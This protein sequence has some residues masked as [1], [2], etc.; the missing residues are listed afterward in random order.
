MISNYLPPGRNRGYELA[1]LNLS[2]GLRGRGHDV[3]ILT[4]PSATAAED[5]DFV[6]RNLA[7]R[8]FTT[9]DSVGEDAHASNEFAIRV[10]QLDNTV[11]VL[12]AIRRNRPDHILLFNMVGLGGLA[13]VNAVDATG[14]PWSMNLG[15]WF[16]NELVGGVDLA[17][18]DVFD[19]GVG[20][21]IYRRAR[22]AA[23]SR[24]L[25]N[26]M[27][28]DGVDLGDTVTII[29]RGVIVPEIART[30]GYREGGVVRFVSAGALAPQ[31][32][33][34]HIIEAAAIVAAENE[35]PFVID[36]YG[37]GRRE[38]YEARVAELG[39]AD[40]I[41]FHGHVS[42]QEIVAANASADAFLCPTWEREPGASV[43]IEAGVAGAVP[44]LTATCGPG[45][46]FVDGFSCLKIFPNQD[47]LARAMRRIGRGEVDLEQLG[48]NARRL[49]AYDLSFETSL[50]RLEKF[51]AQ[52]RDDAPARRIDDPQLDKEIVL[53]DARAREL[54]EQLR[55]GR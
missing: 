16:P 6:W 38:F 12:D 47:S 51:L 11:A 48:A 8:E 4:S 53:K 1:C 14:I 45:E 55:E 15:D 28:G 25:V 37:T 18:R 24:T 42:Q 22:T 36:V 52:P 43:A 17:I 39:L 40:R 31:K 54:F 33:I 35:F 30:R 26:E 13:I 50:D 46:W 41:T 2:R 27:R 32:G 19:A 23:V 44:V 49:A 34:G 5:Q 29:P 10:T 9:A 20:T 21:P 3:T 7:Q